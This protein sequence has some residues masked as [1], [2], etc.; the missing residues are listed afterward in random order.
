MNRRDFLKIAAVSAAPRARAAN[1]PST[2]IDTHA[3]FYDPSRPGGVPWPPKDDS[4][5]YRTVLPAEFRAVAGPLGVKSVIKIEASP[6]L[7]DNQWVLDLAA[8]EPV[9]V[10]VVGNLEPGKPD[11]GRYLD[12]FRKDR[13]FLGIRRGN[14]WGRNFA[15][16]SA[17]PEFTSDLK[18]LADAGLQ[19]DA[20]GGPAMLPNLVRVTDRVPGLRIVIDHM[21]FNPPTEEGARAAYREALRELGTRK[22]VYCKVSSVLRRSDGRVPEDVDFYR[23]ALDELWEVFGAGRLIY[24]SNWPV[25]ERIAPYAKVFGVVHDYFTAKGQ[26]VADQYFWQNAKAAYRWSS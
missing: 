25:S 4:T 17:K 21:P 13:K 1:E 23:P 5:L 8:K 19:M 7:E 6:L 12:R 18:L 24:G 3:H 15:A 11:F 10:G 20:V 22:Q 16:D 2:I 14:L 26:Q 9:I